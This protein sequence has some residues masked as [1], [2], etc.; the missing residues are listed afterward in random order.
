VESR[1]EKDIQPRFLVGIAKQTG[2]P[3]ITWKLFNDEVT[4][5]VPSRIFSFITSHCIINHK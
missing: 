3:D 4:H 1:R 5:G 2:F